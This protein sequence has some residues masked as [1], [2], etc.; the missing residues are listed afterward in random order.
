[1][2]V[3]VVGVDAKTENG[4]DLVLYL[5]EAEGDKILLKELIGD[6]GSKNYYF[7]YLEIL[8]MKA[9]RDSRGPYITIKTME[10]SSYWTVAFTVTKPLSL[11]LL[12]E[13]PISEEGKAIG[14]TGKISKIEPEKE[15]I[16]LSPVI[17]KHKDR[18]AP[19]RGKELYGEINPEA[20]YY[21]FTGVKGKK[22][23]ISYA[24]KDILPW[25][26]IEDEKERAKLKKKIQI[27]YTKEEWFEYLEKKLAER[28][29]G[30]ADKDREAAMR[31]G[32]VMGATN[33]PVL[34]H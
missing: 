11:K 8:S 23:T 18:L 24:D 22:I 32:I 28:H 26:D 15:L 3:L 27:Q 30:K 7:R 17:V 4:N 33:A 14:V 29:G 34:S 5:D 16:I 2:I 6:T 21:T 25:S 10:P 19:K 13:E 1:M 9:G 20:L 12:M 31:A